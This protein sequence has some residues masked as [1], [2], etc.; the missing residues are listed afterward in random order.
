M[1]ELNGGMSR[2]DVI[3]EKKGNLTN[4]W[5]WIVKSISYTDRGK[6]EKDKTQSKVQS[7]TSV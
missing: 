1:S 7:E 5:N 6:G 3:R 4:I 2:P